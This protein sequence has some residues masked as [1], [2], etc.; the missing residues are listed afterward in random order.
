METRALSF[1]NQPIYVGL[2]THRKS[3]KTCIL[4]KNFEHKTFTQPPVSQALI[5]YLHR[6]FPGANYYCAYEA[7]YSGYW[8]QRQLAAAGI[9]CLIVHP[10]DVPTTHKEQVM[11]NDR[12]DARKLAHALRNH[13]LQSI[14][15]ADKEAIEDR[16]LVRVRSEFVRKQTR[17][18]NQIKGFLYFH[19]FELPEDI[20]DRHWSR[21]YIQWISSIEFDHLSAKQALDALLV[22]LE[23]L[24]ASITTLTRQIRTLASEERYRRAVQLLTTIPGISCLSAMILLTELVDIHRFKH[25]NYLASFMGLVPGEHSSG[26]RHT[27]TGMTRRR[28]AQ[29]RH[30]LIEC[31]WVA[32]RK[33]P[34]LILAFNQ[35]SQRMSKNNAII[36]IAR[37]LLNRIQFVLKNNQPYVAGVVETKKPM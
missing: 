17:C 2:D 4:T 3:W 32:A 1:K 20:Q 8:I 30:L 21:R 12:S 22:E 16:T 37:K 18:K 26:E 6:H 29:L 9:S 7:G 35:L 28:N 15:I 33:D 25:S 13:Q 27:T 24:R 11:K 31:A 10:A 19:G 23:Q 5:G 34:A 14:Y 36:R